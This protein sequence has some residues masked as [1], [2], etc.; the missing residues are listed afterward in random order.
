M[1]KAPHMR[2][3]LLVTASVFAAARMMS[4]AVLLVLQRPA[5]R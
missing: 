4:D 1:K 5:I 2:G 3:F